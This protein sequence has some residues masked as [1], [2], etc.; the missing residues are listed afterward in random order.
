LFARAETAG[1]GRPARN[2][3]F[4]AKRATT[5]EEWGTPVNL[6][7]VVNNGLTLGASV[8]ADELELYFHSDR[9]GGYG[10]VDVWVTTR[11]TVDDDWGTPV[12]L[13]PTID[14][15]SADNWP[16]ISSDGLALFFS[17]TRPGGSG[18]YD[19]YAARRATRQAPWGPLEN[20]GPLVNSAAADVNPKVPFDGSTLYF[21]PYPRGIWQ[22]PIVPTVDFNADGAVD[23]ID[24]VTLIDDWGTNR[25][26]CDIEP[27]PWG[28]GKV[29]IEDLKVFMTYYEKENPPVQP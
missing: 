3:I 27:M 16:G 7:P 10:G 8:P 24:L 19:L 13:G 14:T 25:T 9:P 15:P 29:D 6:G 22:A 5:N 21:C 28:D 26:L 2:I 23:L 20:L 12:N 11:A 18:G 17:S 1:T 4:V